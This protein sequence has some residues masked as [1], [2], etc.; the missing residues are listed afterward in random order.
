MSNEI[1]PVG[2]ARIWRLEI[3]DAATEDLYDPPRLLAIV[4]KPSGESGVETAY[5]Y[6]IDEEIERESVGRYRMTLHFD[7]AGSWVRRW[8]AFDVDDNPLESTER[9]F[10][11]RTSAAQEPL[12]G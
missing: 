2:Q 10:R 7:V 6:G 5:E 12:G 9:S 8:Q 1:F 4:Q 3:R 11:V